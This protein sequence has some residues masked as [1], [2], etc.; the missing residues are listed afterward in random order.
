P[1]NGAAPGAPGGF[2]G[3][4]P[5]GV[6]GGTG[7]G[8]GSNQSIEF[9]SSVGTATSIVEQG[10]KRGERLY[11][12]QSAYNS[13]AVQK[14]AQSAKVAKWMGRASN[15]V[16]IIA[17]TAE[18]INTV[19]NPNATGADYAKIGAK[20]GVAYLSNALN[21]AAPGLGIVVGI[22]LN[23]LIDEYGEDAYESITDSFN[24]DRLVL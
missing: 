6:S 2:S 22:G 4:G 23:Y 3:A 19:N 12:R 13:K 20:I 11:N 8:T 5:G 21:V 10:A 14:A 17:I 15:A 7:T 16:N 18:F 24:N 1:S 9:I